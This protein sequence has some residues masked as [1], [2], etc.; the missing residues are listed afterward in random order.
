MPS[1]GLLFASYAVLP[2][3]GRKLWRIGDTGAE[4]RRQLTH[5]RTLAGVQG[6]IGIAFIATIGIFHADQLTMHFMI[7]SMIWVASASV[8]FVAFWAMAR[9]EARAAVH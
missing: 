3:D 9:M 4:Q 1:A 6:S 8:Y 7:T 2:R 5:I